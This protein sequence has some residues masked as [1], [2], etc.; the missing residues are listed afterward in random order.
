MRPGL[1]EGFSDVI[2][3]HAHG[4]IAAR[5][6]VIPLHLIGGHII[7][8]RLCRRNSGGS[9][10]ANGMREK[11]GS[12]HAGCAQ[13]GRCTSSLTQFPSGGVANAIRYRHSRKV[14]P[15]QAVDATLACSLLA[16]VWKPKVILGR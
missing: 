3:L 15:A 10:A 12:S 8:A 14:L 13:K 5:R 16:G 11:N 1:R 9:M 2:K 7:C 4:F 6:R